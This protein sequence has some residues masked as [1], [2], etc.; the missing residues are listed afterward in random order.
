M[1]FWVTQRRP[2]HQLTPYSRH[3][4]NAPWSARGDFG[5]ANQADNPARLS[6]EA[7]QSLALL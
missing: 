1:I 3:G 5:E 6:G 2:R 4:A 7:T